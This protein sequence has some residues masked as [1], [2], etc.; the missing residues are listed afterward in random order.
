MFH[1]TKELLPWRKRPVS[2]VPLL[3]RFLCFQGKNPLERGDRTFELVVSEVSQFLGPGTGFGMAL[4][5]LE[6]TLLLLRGEGGDDVRGDAFFVN[7]LVAGGEIF[8][9][10]QPDGVRPTY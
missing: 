6:N 2:K 9:C 1:E 5:P 8:G 3:F 10:G 4:A 7:G